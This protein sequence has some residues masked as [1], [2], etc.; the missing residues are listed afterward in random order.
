MSRQPKHPT[1]IEIHRAFAPIDSALHQLQRGEVLEA[2]DSDTW[3]PVLRDEHD[4][5]RPI[6]PNLQAWAGAWDALASAFALPLDN[7]PL[8]DLADQLAGEHI[9]I[10]TLRAAQEL[11]HLQ[12]QHYRRLP[13]YRVRQIVQTYQEGIQQ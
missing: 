8:R 11:V 2:R 1:L 10:H 6:I 4:D 5:L 9:Q 12:R 13:P 7:Q 3:V